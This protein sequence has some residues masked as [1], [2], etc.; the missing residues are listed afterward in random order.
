MRVKMLK[1]I[2][3]GCWDKNEKDEAEMKMLT[4]S[5]MGDFPDP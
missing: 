5:G 1:G 3:N 2:V 4:L